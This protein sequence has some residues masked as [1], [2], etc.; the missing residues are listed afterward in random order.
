M[1]WICGLI[2]RV[3]NS[4]LLPACRSRQAADRWRA[5]AQSVR[6]RIATLETQL[7]ELQVTLPPAVTVAE[8]RERQGP[9]LAGTGSG[10][11][12]DESEAEGEASM[13]ENSW[14]EAAGMAL[15]VL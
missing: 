2:A 4:A 6:D 1:H 5:E 3:P 10:V 9:G 12:S 15:H 11:L 14:V 8:D 13:F 7:R